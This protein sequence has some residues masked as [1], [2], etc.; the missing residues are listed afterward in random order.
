ML[1]SIVKKV[2]FATQEASNARLLVYSCV[3]CNLHVTILKVSVASSSLNFYFLFF[4]HE[5]CTEYD[6]E[7]GTEC[8]HLAQKYG[9][10]RA[11]LIDGPESLWKVCIDHVYFYNLFLWS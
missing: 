11:L 1:R 4:V 6:F 5:K 7:F 8:L 3:E 9:E 2:S 10:T